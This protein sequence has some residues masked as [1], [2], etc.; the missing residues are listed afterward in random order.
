MSNIAGTP[1]VM[2]KASG[3][4]TA[5]VIFFHGLGDQGHGWAQMFESEMK[6]PYVKGVFP[7]AADRPVSLNYGMVM[8]A[9]YDIFGL[10]IDSKEDVEGIQRATKYVHDLINAEIKAGISSERIVIGGFSMGG[11]LAIYAG[12][13]FDKPLGGIIGLSSFLLQRQTLP[14]NH[15]AN[16]KTPIFLGHGTEDPLV[17]FQFGKMTSEE[18]AKFNNHV[19]LKSYRMGHTSSPAEISDVRGFLV[20]NLP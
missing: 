3:K 9:W 18:I 2:V 13:T 5:S 4:Q 15:T 16:L 8:P 20:K 17:P 10:S 1:P 14:G 12:L 11:A 6:L 7:N 19:E